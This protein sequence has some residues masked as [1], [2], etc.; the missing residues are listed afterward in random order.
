MARTVDTA[1]V[2]N[3]A[4]VLELIHEVFKRVLDSVEKLGL[5]QTLD[6]PVRVPIVYQLVYQGNKIHI[7]SEY[8][9]VHCSR[10]RPPGTTK[11]WFKGTRVL[12]QGPDSVP[13]G[14]SALWFVFRMSC[15]Q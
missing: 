8:K 1:T 15:V 9:D 10:K 4:K 2:W 7:M 13:S 5:D 3:E 12:S 11:V 14:Q 6:N